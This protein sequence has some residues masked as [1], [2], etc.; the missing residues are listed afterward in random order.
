MDTTDSAKRIEM[1]HLRKMGHLNGWANFRLRWTFRGESSG[2]ICARINTL[3][4]EGGSYMELDYKTRCGDEEWRDLKYR[5]ELQGTAC[6][7][8]GLRWWFIC[9][10]T[11]CKRRNSI[12]YQ[13]GDY[14]VCRKCARLKYSSQEY[15]GKYAL[16]SRLFK[17]DDYEATM[18][19]WYYRGKPT[20]RHR[21]LLKMRHGMTAETALRAADRLLTGVLH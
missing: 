13:Y 10:N 4:F 19:R 14:F 16:L 21:R 20:R 2:N 15:S 7:F 12:L 11:N 8:G 17:A 6:R 9:P 5:V 3:S 18:K 1:T